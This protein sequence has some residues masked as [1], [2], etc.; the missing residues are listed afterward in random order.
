MKK[1][2]LLAALVV[3]VSVQ[4]ETRCGW[5]VQ[6]RGASFLSLTDR[7]GEWIANGV[8]TD[9]DGKVRNHEAVIANG[10]GFDDAQTTECGCMS[11]ATDPARKL[12]KAI[13]RYTV[14]PNKACQA[15]RALARI[16]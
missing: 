4:A 12:I 9:L 16:H 1:L 7:D 6:E 8:Y 3:S 2:I 5:V 15:D 10:I 11:V 13:T 14:K